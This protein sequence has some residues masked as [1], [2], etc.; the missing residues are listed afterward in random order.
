MNVAELILA[1]QKMPQD[2]AVVIAGYEGGVDDV[3]SLEI[4]RIKRN[5][6]PPDM[7]YFG[8]HVVIDREEDLK[9]DWENGEE[10][11]QIS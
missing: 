10:A 3:T 7:D 1:L 8:E 11:V 6:H 9:G 4:V 5:V 2:E